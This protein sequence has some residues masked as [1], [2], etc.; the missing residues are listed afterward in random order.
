MRWL[1]YNHPLLLGCLY[2]AIV[3]AVVALIG[4]IISLHV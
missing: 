3:Y 1:R 2:L 4:Y